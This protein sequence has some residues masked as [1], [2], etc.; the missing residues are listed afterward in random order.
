MFLLGK[1]ERRAQEC[2]IPNKNWCVKIFKYLAYIMTW[3]I[4]VENPS[5][6]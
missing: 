6:S 1:Q 5:I 3:D 2:F 4:Q